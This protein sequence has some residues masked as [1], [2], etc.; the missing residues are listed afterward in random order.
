MFRELL[1]DLCVV[2]GRVMARLGLSIGPSVLAKGLRFWLRL[3]FRYDH[4]RL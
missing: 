3:G 2:V 1:I 4:T